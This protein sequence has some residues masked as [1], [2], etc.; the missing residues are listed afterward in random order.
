MQ[1]FSYEDELNSDF[2]PPI[3]LW[4][5]VEPLLP[6]PTRT[7]KVGPKAKPDQPM[8]AAIDYRMR[9]G[10]R[11]NALPKC[12]RAGSTM[13]D[14]HQQWVRAGVF[15]TWWEHGWLQ[16]NVEGALHWSFQS[17]DGCTPK[18]P[19][20]GQQTGANPTDRGK[21]STKRHILGI[22][23]KRPNSSRLVQPIIRPI[24]PVSR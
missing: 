24:L 16:L 11:W 13:H 9:T 2:L 20:G 22:I 8:F 1:A 4:L 21:T 23:K 17:I 10:C 6:Q 5:A 7:A 3:S 18:A 12:L 14:R 15:E 19:L